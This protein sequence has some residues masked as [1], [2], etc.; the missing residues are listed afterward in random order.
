MGTNPL[1]DAAEKV[2]ELEHG[3]REMLALF[4]KLCWQH[5]SKESQRKYERY[6]MSPTLYAV[7]IA[8]QEQLLRNAIEYAADILNEP[9]TYEEFDNSEI[10]V[11]RASA[12]LREGSF[13]LCLIGG[14]ACAG[15]IEYCFKEVMPCVYVMS[16]DFDAETAYEHYLHGDR[17]QA[18]TVLTSCLHIAIDE[19]KDL[20]KARGRKFLGFLYR[21]SDTGQY[22]IDNDVVN[23]FYYGYTSF[24]RVVE[25][26]SGHA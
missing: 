3:V 9:I 8:P 4:N 13:R 11:R 1:H 26:I 24:L 5:A 15:D 20:E 19:L 23:T 2:R 10:S 14:D 7:T 25:P 22:H 6:A 21:E 16:G 18:Q 17:D 12:L